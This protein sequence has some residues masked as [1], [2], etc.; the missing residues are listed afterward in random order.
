MKC[1]L[2]AAVELLM[3]MGVGMTPREFSHTTTP[4]FLIP[5]GVVSLCVPWQ[6]TPY[7]EA[8]TPKTNT[9]TEQR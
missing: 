1:L 5:R 2:S 9:G 3:W 6:I 4:L 7:N 8:D